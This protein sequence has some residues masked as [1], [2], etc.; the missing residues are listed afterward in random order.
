[1]SSKRWPWRKYL[2]HDEAEKV[3]KAE[4]L[5]A[6]YDRHREFL[7]VLRDKRPKADAAAINEELARV[8]EV[9]QAEAARRTVI[10]N[11]ATH[12][13]KLRSRNLEEM[14]A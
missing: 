9:R 10:V 3:D 2:A 4:T 8:R 11:R 14:R 5:L 12:R 13:A 7:L 1:M 6:V